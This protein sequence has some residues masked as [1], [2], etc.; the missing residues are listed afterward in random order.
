MN[1]PLIITYLN[2]QK[3]EFNK[4]INNNYIL[5]IIYFI[6]MHLKNLFYMNVEITINLILKI[7]I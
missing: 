5:K 2:N 1:H 6:Y 3:Q 4:Y 7:V